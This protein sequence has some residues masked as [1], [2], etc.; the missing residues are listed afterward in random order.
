MME[1][2][3]SDLKC[4]ADV[5]VTFEGDNVVM[6]QVVARELLAQYTKQHKDQ[7]LAGLLWSWVAS[8]S[9]KLRTSFLAF[10]TD[11]IG[12][13]AFLLKAVNFRERV[14]QRCLVARIYYKVKISHVV[15]LPFDS[16]L[17]PS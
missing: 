12:N 7:P 16:C 17:R 3:I 9:D 4:D 2:R 5:F 10:N 14:L 15:F 8:V 1:N 11:A 6:L 13:L